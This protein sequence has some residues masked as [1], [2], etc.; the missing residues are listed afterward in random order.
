MAS[1]AP[2]GSRL[3]LPKLAFPPATIVD[4]LI[5][6]FPNVPAVA[7]RDRIARALV[8]TD[9]GI[10][11]REDTPYRHGIMVLYQREV[12]GEPATM[13]AEEII[14]RDDE[15]LVADKPHGMPV[16][17]AGDY[18]E[19]SLLV[20]LRRSTGLEDLTPMHRLDRDT[21]GIVLF[22]I[23]RSS[24]PEYHRLFAEGAIERAYLAV[25]RIAETTNR[26][27]WRVENRMASGDPWYRQEI[28]EGKANAITSI[29]L[30]E[31]RRGAGLFGLRPESG[32]KHQL[33]VH[34]AS[35]GFPIIGDHVYPELRDR[36]DGEPPLQLL[37]HRLAFTDPLTG[38]PRVLESQRNLI[39]GTMPP[40]TVVDCAPL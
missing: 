37:A 30:L 11:V 15:I 2:L 4:F 8:T 22:A 1:A 6:R 38:A 39:W 5:G 13:V 19:R 9:D 28:V 14:H 20:R 21:A 18:V 31:S 26:T 23:K 10:L 29:E 35:V 3:R 40:R 36:I 27:R 32:R 7:W 25:A 12:P 34:M 33:R 17:P 16:T 24:R